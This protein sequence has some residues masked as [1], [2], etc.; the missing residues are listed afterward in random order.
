MLPT[1]VWSILYVITTET[2]I[3]IYSMIS[4]FWQLPVEILVG[5]ASVWVNSSVRVE[6]C[7]S[8]ASGSA[9][10]LWLISCFHG[11]TVHCNTLGNMLV[12]KA[13][14]N[15]VTW[16]LYSFILK[17]PYTPSVLTILFLGA[18]VRMFLLSVIAAVTT[19]YRWRQ[20]DIE[21]LA[22]GHSTK[23]WRPPISWYSVQ[24]LSLKIALKELLAWI[25]C[26]FIFL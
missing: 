14:S 23:D 2:W 6:I 24:F 10:E 13:L 9:W 5:E 26:S 18:V 25:F 1:Q 22:R 17:S 12:D 15:S 19:V 21:E 20:W 3:S 11:H 16:C 7:Y 8:Y 4:Q